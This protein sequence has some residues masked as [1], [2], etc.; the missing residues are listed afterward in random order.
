MKEEKKEIV[1]RV[2]RNNISCTMH[3]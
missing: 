3:S 1:T 2:F